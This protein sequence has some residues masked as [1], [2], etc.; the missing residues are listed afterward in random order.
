MGSLRTQNVCTVCLLFQCVIKDEAYYGSWVHR[1][2]I[3]H[4]LGVGS[5]LLHSNF[6]QQNVK[7]S[8]QITI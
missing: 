7:H 4:W 2:Y 5:L 3:E 6:I 8:K 1:H